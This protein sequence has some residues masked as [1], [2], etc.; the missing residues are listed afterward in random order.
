MNEYRISKTVCIVYTRFLTF[1]IYKHEPWSYPPCMVNPHCD[2]DW[3]LLRRTSIGPSLILNTLR[4]KKNQQQ[5]SKVGSCF[6][7]VGGGLL[8]L[9]LPNTTRRSC[10]HRVKRWVYT[11]IQ[12]VRRIYIG[13]DASTGECQRR[14]MSSVPPPPHVRL[15][16]EPWL[17]V[18]KQRIEILIYFV[19]WR[20][21]LWKVEEIC[22][23]QDKAFLPTILSYSVNSV[24]FMI[25]VCCCVC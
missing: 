1:W 3:F 10:S 22:V 13:A 15:F 5:A 21:D 19:I 12:H 7:R 14:I 18:L 16:S 8:Y 24:S 20:R 17:M 23:T 9:Y 6:A 25:R 11:Y 4:R 2:P